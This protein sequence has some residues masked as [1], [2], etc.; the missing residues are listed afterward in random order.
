MYAN[1]FDAGDAPGHRGARNL[2]PNVVTFDAAQTL[3]HVQWSPALLGEDIAERT[4]LVADAQWAG[5]KLSDL[6]RSRWPAYQCVNLERSETAGD[7]FWQ[8]LLQDWLALMNLGSQKLPEV[9]EACWNLLYGPEQSYFSIYDDV[10]PCL[11]ALSQQNIRVAVISNWDYSL[12]RIL[13]ML[14]VHDHFELVVAS[15]EEGPEKPDP[16]LFALT[17]ERLGASP[18]ETWHVGDNPIDDLQGAENFGMTGILIDRS[19]EDSTPKS[20]RTLLELPDLWKA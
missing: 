7:A 10:L 19:R 2:K 4:S 18:S 16:A 20:I 12:H 17:L 3:V 5:G 1:G 14:R 9:E 6:L 8:Q 11:D 15:L 13:K